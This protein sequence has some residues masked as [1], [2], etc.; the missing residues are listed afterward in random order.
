MQENSQKNNGSINY[1]DFN[2][3]NIQQSDA[4]KAHT[5]LPATGDN[6]EYTW[7]IIIATIIF[8]IRTIRSYKRLKGIK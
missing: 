4:S 8:I 5:M 6:N 7:I 1:T 2:N 3:S